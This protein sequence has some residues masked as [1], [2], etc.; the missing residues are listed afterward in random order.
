MLRKSN[1]LE[2]DEK[3][4]VAD[5]RREV[6]DHF[7]AFDCSDRSTG[8]AEDPVSVVI[9]NLTH[10]VST[11]I[12]LNLINS[13]DPW[14]NR[15]FMEFKLQYLQG[16]KSIISEC[17]W[18]REVRIRSKRANDYTLNLCYEDFISRTSFALSCPCLWMQLMKN[19]QRWWLF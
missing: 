14:K 10:D 12:K 18:Q 5:P 6:R 17:S 16:R 11:K 15:A 8:N 4:R 1:W 3:V 2:T 13:R 9:P 19:I 7:C